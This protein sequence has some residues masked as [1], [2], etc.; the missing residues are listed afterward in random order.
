MDKSVLLADRLPRG[1]V[2]VPGVGTVALRALSRYELVLAGKGTE[3]SALIE[4]RLLSYTLLDP[5]LSVDEVRQWQRSAPSGEVGLVVDKMR[6]LS[7][8]GEGAD[9]SSVSGP[10]DEP[11]A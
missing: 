2:E 11:G 7:G 9:K 4:A 6:E 8:L 3:D 10:G 5:Q 1:E